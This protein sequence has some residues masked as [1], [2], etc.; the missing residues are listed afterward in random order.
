[1]T[2]PQRFWDKVKTSDTNSYGGTPCQE[3]TAYTDKDDYGIFWL[4]G[5]PQR[6]HRVSYELF[7]GSITKGLTI[8]HLCKNTSCVNPDHLEAVTQRE[9][10][11]RGNTI[12]AENLAKTHCPGGH[13]YTKENTYFASGKYGKSRNCRICHNIQ[14]K[15]YLGRKNGL[16]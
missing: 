15:N 1:M 12:V 6:A 16:S 14:Q 5:T 4:N 8:D 3:W 10:I 9:N 13:E 7:R 2:L 11:L